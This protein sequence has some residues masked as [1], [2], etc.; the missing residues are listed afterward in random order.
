MILPKSAYDVSKVLICPLNW[1]LGHAARCIPIIKFYL[2]HRIEVH[3][4]SDGPA[5]ELLKMEFPKLQAHLLPSYDIHY[6]YSSMTYNMGTQLFKIN[7]AIQ[8]EKTAIKH[9][10]KRFHFDLII[11][12]HRFGCLYP[13]VKS[14]IIAHQ[15]EIKSKNPLLSKMASQ[16][17][18][19]HINKFDSCWIPDHSEQTLSGTLSNTKGLKHYNFIGPLSRFKKQS[20]K[21]EYDIAIILSGPEP[22][23]TELEDAILKHHN[24][25]RYKTTL[26]RGIS[27]TKNAKYKPLKI[28]HCNV[29]DFANSPTL[30]NIINKSRLLVSR[31][32][33]SSLM[34]YD[35]LKKSAILIP[36]P[37]Q[38]EQEYLAEHHQNSNRFSF[39]NHNRIDSLPKLI[40]KHLIRRLG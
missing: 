5:L 9:L 28:K 11:S 24:F 15:I 30:N 37:G 10:Q 27:K 3:I 31:A 4:A 36:T 1:G 23:R 2:D 18:L 8:K 16:A 12:D 35:H 22:K 20:L 17:N 13:T 7:A 38:T 40:E 29:L 34:D 26:V 21:P 33:Y 14:I 19:Y 25:D 32:G 6:K 39:L